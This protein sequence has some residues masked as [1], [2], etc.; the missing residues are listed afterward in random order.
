MKIPE[1]APKP[2]DKL[3]LAPI[4][5]TVTDERRQLD[6]KHLE[7]TGDLKKALRMLSFERN[8]RSEKNSVYDEFQPFEMPTMEEM[9]GMRVDVNWPFNEDEEEGGEDHNEWV[10][11]RKSS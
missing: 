8:V 9:V 2:P 7:K 4:L 5:G 11:P 6:L 3:A 10:V 1:E